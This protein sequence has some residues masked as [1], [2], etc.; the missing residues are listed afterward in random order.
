MMEAI[1]QG[2]VDK[3]GAFDVD[4]VDSIGDR[5]SA[6]PFTALFAACIESR[7]ESVLWL[8][9]NGADVNRVEYKSMHQ[10]TPLHYAAMRGSKACAEILILSGANPRAVTTSGNTAVELAKEN[11]H[12]LEAAYISSFMQGDPNAQRKVEKNRARLETLHDKY[13]GDQSEQTSRAVK[14]IRSYLSRANDGVGSKD[15]LRASHSTVVKILAGLNM[16]ISACYLVWRALFSLSTGWWYFY[17]MT[18]WLAEAVGITLSSAFFYSSGFAI[19]RQDRDLVT[20]LD[21]SLYPYVDVIICY[22]GTGGDE[23]GGAR[24]AGVAQASFTTTGS[25]KPPLKGG[26]SL[27]SRFSKDRKSQGPPPIRIDIPVDENVDTTTGRIQTEDEDSSTAMKKL[28][29]TVTSV[30]NLDYPGTKLRVI[31]VNNSGDPGVYEMMRVLEFQLKYMGRKAELRCVASGLGSAMV[32]DCGKRTEYVLVLHHDKIVHPMLLRKSLGHFY[33]R[34]GGSGGEG[35]LLWTKK[36]CAGMLQFPRDFWNI[37]R[38][39]GLIQASRASNRTQLQGLD[40]VGACPCWGHGVIVRKDVLVSI[41]GEGCID[42]SYGEI[43]FPTEIKLSMD[44]LSSGYSTMLLNRSMVYSMAP[45]T[46]HQLYRQQVLFAAESM[47]ILWTD[48]PLRRVGLS[49]SQSTLLW[50][51]CAHHLGAISIVYLALVPVLYILAEASPV[52]VSRIWE[53]VVVF[54]AYFVCNRIT[55]WW[56]HLDVVD[57]HIEMWRRVRSAVWMSPWQITAMF[58]VGLGWVQSIRSKGLGIHIP[59]FSSGSIRKDHMS[60]DTDTHAGANVHKE[61]ENATEASEY[62]FSSTSEVFTSIVKYTPLVAPYIAYYCTAVAATTYFVV[63]AASGAYPVWEIILKLVAL[64]W[65]YY[66]AVCCWPPC[67]SIIPHDTGISGWIIMWFPAAKR[68]LFSLS[69]RIKVEGHEATRKVFN[70]L[71][72]SSKYVAWTVE[73]A[74]SRSW[75]LTCARSIDTSTGLWPWQTGG[76]L[77]T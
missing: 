11:G 74:H 9:E 28:E 52:T 48:N 63:I 36:E 51:T 6:L 60:N 44:I 16:V 30:L 26:T 21:S 42:K 27:L 5:D 59:L 72:R 62:T 58:S 2:Y 18:V 29:A 20:M 13:L 45:E 65:I 4:T 39:D 57:G 40:G 53:F 61:T 34:S 23:S 55:L 22:N 67:H 32:H 41:A 56:A 1:R 37:S 17:S 8:C 68:R 77:T 3:Y 66:I 70:K 64:S 31:V 43:S 19:D 73:L 38:E 25:D 75:T 7:P 76:R 24:I 14:I 50:E 69:S 46:L 33:E 12:I 10:Y 49:A 47:R 15:V 35:R 71:P 54:A